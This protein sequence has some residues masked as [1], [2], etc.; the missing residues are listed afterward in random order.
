MLRAESDKRAQRVLAAANL[1]EPARGFD[2]HQNSEREEYAGDCRGAQHRAPALGT[3][4]RLV[5]EIGNE[6]ADGDR[7]LIRRDIPTA[8]CGGGEFR[9][10]KG[11]RDRGDADAETRNEPAKDKDRHVRGEGLS[12]RA[13][14]EKSRRNKERALPAEKVGRVAASERPEQGAQRDP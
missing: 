13:A 12:E 9:R 14:D 8:L 11:S 3:R 5:D 10:I 6:N 1:R 4:K 7:E 2:R